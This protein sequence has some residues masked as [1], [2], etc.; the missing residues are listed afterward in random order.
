MKTRLAI[1]GVLLS[2]GALLA[3][4]STIRPLSFED[5]VTQAALVVQGTV[6]D[7]EI[8]NFPECLLGSDGHYLNNDQP[9]LIIDPEFW[10][11]FM[12][13]GFHQCVHRSYCGA[14]RCL[15]LNTAYV[16]KFGWHADV[17]VPFP[18]ENSDSAKL[19]RAEPE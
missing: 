19:A 14:Q 1:S 5:R 8:K 16:E 15:G 2:G 7:L 18:R 9:K 12:R 11:E 4:A 3:G 13:N 6:V 17:L 10:P